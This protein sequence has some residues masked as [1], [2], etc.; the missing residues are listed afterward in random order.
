MATSEASMES[1]DTIAAE[2][3][4]LFKRVDYSTV[5]RPLKVC[6]M[7]PIEKFGQLTLSIWFE[8]DTSKCFVGK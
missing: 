8:L 5:I 2:L 4:R 3:M 6:D 1:K 7:I